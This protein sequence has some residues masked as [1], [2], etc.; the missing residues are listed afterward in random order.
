MRATA[1][2]ASPDTLLFSGR[3]AEPLLRHLYLLYPH[4]SSAGH[5]SVIF[6]ISYAEIREEGTGG[7]RGLGSISRRPDHLESTHGCIG[8]GPYLRIGVSSP[9]QCCLLRRHVNLN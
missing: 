5:P 2:W 6:S 9:S 3:R 1:T 8:P 4:R 7:W